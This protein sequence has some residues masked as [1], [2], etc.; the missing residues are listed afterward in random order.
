MRKVSTK[1]VKMLNRSLSLLMATGFAAS[2]V[3]CTG[4]FAPQ[5]PGSDDD[6]TPLPPPPPPN[7][8]GTAPPVINPPPPGGTVTYKRGSL[9][10][11]FQL[12]PRAEYGRMDHKGIVMTDSDFETN[13]VTTSVSL[14]MDP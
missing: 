13:Q 8:A 6:S 4:Q 3:A 7:D 5:T 2:V 9:P 1:V 10:P 14:K 11:V 12:T